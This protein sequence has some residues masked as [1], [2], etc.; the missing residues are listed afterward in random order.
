[1]PRPFT[2]IRRVQFAETDAA[3]ILHFANYF[4]IMEETEHA[5]WRSMGQSI[6]TPKDGKHVGWPRVATECEYFEPA[7]FEDEIELTFVVTRV[8]DQSYSFEVR[9]DCRGK[10]IA[11]A[12]TTAVCCL[13]GDGQVCKTPIPDA[14][15][16][17]LVAAMATVPN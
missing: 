1:M 9:F 11:I 17:E 8:G 2:M 7:R 13:C 4:R 3:G 6:M 5:F 15:R 10:T 16:S 12:K 14:I